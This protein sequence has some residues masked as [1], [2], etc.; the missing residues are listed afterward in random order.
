M[1]E[2]SIYVARDGGEELVMENVGWMETDGE[3]IR[4]KDIDGVEKTVRGRIKYADL[5]QHRVV[6]EPATD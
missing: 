2:S 4:M 5:V 1:C 6:L 3:T